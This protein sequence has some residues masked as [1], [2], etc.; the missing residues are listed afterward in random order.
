MEA[1][2]DN[3][4]SRLDPSLGVEMHHDLVRDEL[5]FDLGRWSVLCVKLASGWELRRPADV[6]WSRRTRGMVSAMWRTMRGVSPVLHCDVVRGVSPTSAIV[7]IRFAHLRYRSLPLFLLCGAARHGQFLEI[8]FRVLCTGGRYLVR[9]FAVEA[10]GD[11]TALIDA[12]D[13]LRAIRKDTIALGTLVVVWRG[14]TRWER[15]GL[16]FSRNWGVP[17]QFSRTAR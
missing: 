6:A 16:W 8:A 12:L 13:G 9:P 1:R 5:C 7:R 3:S 4:P 2:S 14:P 10:A 17:F 11:T 15:R